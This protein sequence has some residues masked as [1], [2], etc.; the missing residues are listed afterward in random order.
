MMTKVLVACE[1]SQA[2][3]IELRKLGI[4]AY[5]CD[6]FECSGGHPEWHLKQ[7]VIPL[8][9]KKWDMIIAFPPCT[10]L[11]CSG[12]R[13]F[14]KKRADGRQQQGIDFFMEF[15]NADC[16]YIAIENPVGIMSTKYRKPDQIIQPYQFGDKA[17]KTT[18]LWLKGLPKLKHTKI[19][20]KGEFYISPSGKKMAK[21]SCD[22]IGKNGKK[23]AYNSAEIKKLR[24]KTFQGIA[25]AM[26][27]QW[28]KF[29]N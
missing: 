2:V 23:I 8:L 7:D 21:W 17:Q 25:K 20:D 14:A 3:T 9:K 22:P 28:G 16:D 15:V 1:E 12:A 18:C 13:H 5:S 26:A 6:I 11:A 4:E 27:S 10:H 29:I 24:S 19:V